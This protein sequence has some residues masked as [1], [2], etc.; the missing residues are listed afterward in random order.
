[1]NISKITCCLF[2]IV[3]FINSCSHSNDFKYYE[4][5]NE[6]VVF[7]DNNQSS[8]EVGDTLWL[9]INIESK[10]N[11]KIAEQN[12]I[13]SDREID[14]FNL[15]KATETF[16]GF[17]VFQINE[18]NFSELALDPDNVIEEMGRL[19]VGSSEDTSLLGVAPYSDG[20]YQLHVGIPLENAGNYF[21][22]NSGNGLG[23]SRLTFN[24]TNGA[25]IN[26]NFITKIR[27][28]DSDGRFYFTVN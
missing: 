27:N 25:G 23:R 11:G 19:N 10:Q 8:Y 9:N 2:F 6:E 28:S 7:I 21:L 13:I 1:M 16:F 24:P 17:S 15:T 3:I 20:K 14:I 18:E 5:E 12:E 22:A 4:I 26:V